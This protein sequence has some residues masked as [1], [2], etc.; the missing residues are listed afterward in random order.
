[1]IILRQGGGAAE[2]EDH[3]AYKEKRKELFHKN[4]SGSGRRASRPRGEHNTPSKAYH[5]PGGKAI[6]FRGNILTNR[7]FLSKKEGARRGVSRVLPKDAANE[8][9]KYKMRLTKGK[10][11]W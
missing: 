3:A 8:S 6:R 9:T 7:C 2:G 10:T 11:V 1:M 4:T 5:K